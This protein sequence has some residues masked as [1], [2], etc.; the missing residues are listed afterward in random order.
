MKCGG[1]TNSGCA[2]ARSFA[3]VQWNASS[4][5]SRSPRRTIRGIT[6]FEEKCRDMP[7]ISQV[8]NLLQDLRYA[9]R[10]A[11][12]HDDRQGRRLG[13]TSEYAPDIDRNCHR[14]AGSLVLTKII[15]GLLYRLTTTDPSRFTGTALLFAAVALMGTYIPAWRRS[16]RRPQSGESE[17]PQ[18]A[19]AATTRVGKDPVAVFFLGPAARWG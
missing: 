17:P 5:A 7:R 8:E 6:Q 15:S 16:I 1:S 13:N 12:R 11:R 3:A 18:P 19:T 9:F 4:D 2:G 10:G 14:V